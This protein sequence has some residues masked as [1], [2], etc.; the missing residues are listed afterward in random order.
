MSD[1]LFNRLENLIIYDKK[2]CFTLVSYIAILII[3]T[4]SV[5][6]RSSILGVI[7]TAVFFLINSFF[8]GNAFFRT[9]SYLI[10]LALGSLLLIIFLG[11]IGWITMVVYNLDILRSTVVLSI[12]SA[13]S[14]FFNRGMKYKDENSIR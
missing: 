12:I 10:R 9:E 2:F 13:L 3:F 7:A 11:L 1:S 4:N 6:F 5:V 14:S 8:L